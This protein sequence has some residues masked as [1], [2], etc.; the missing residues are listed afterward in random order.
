[1]PDQVV[2]LG[3]QPGKVFVRSP[4]RQIHEDDALPV[5]LSSRNFAVRAI[6]IEIDGED[7]G[8][9]EAGLVDASLTHRVGEKAELA[10]ASRS[11]ILAGLEVQYAGFPLSA[12][13][14][15]GQVAA[16]VREG[17]MLGQSAF[18]ILGA[19][20][21]KG[22]SGAVGVALEYLGAARIDYG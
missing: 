6:V 15:Q 2:P 3:R 12:A 17:G 16:V 21:D 8:A 22:L 10:A 1:A 11:E 20:G 9:A 19:V 13:Q 7:G 4:S 5:D 14:G 18:P